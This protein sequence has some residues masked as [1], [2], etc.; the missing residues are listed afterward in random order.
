MIQNITYIFIFTSQNT[1]RETYFNFFRYLS[2][3]KDTQGLITQSWNKA[4]S[5]PLFPNRVIETHWYFENK[6]HDKFLTFPGQPLWVLRNEGKSWS[7]KGGRLM[8]NVNLSSLDP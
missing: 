2:L 3:L 4:V 6:H 8:H 1:I 5:T 7:G